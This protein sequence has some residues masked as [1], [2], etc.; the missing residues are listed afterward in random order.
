MT[1]DPLVR[2]GLARVYVHQRIRSFVGK[3]VEQRA[4]SGEAPGA[5]GSIGKLLW[6]RG[7][8]EISEVV[9]GLLGSRLIADTGEWGTWAWR[10]HLLGAPGY[11]IAG[12]SD[13]IQHNIIAER[14]LGLPRDPR[15][16]PSGSSAGTP[17]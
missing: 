5:E 6:T 9:S 10:E 15:P 17:G 3:R 14:I 16:A 12:G 2:Q 7:M 13:E 1:T 4:A 11:K 8:T